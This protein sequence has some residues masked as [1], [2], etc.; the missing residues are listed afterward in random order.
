ME[1]IYVVMHQF[2]MDGGFGDAVSSD[3]IV[4]ITKNK[5]KALAYVEKWSDPCVYDRPYADLT[6]WDLRVV[7]WDLVDPDL[8]IDPF[9]RDEPGCILAYYPCE[10]TTISVEKTE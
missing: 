6:C 5:E 7:E 4:F 1:K 3:E 2:D 8:S 9:N 10:H